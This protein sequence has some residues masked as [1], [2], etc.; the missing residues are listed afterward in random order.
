L[1]YRHNFPVLNLAH[2]M[3]LIAETDHT[4]IWPMVEGMLLVQLSGGGEHRLVGF[5]SAA[6][7]RTMLERG[8]LKRDGALLHVTK[9]GHRAA[10]RDFVGANKMPRRRRPG[11]TV[12]LSVATTFQGP[13]PT[14][15]LCSDSAPSKYLH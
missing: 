14:N 10:R 12:C 5:L 2:V 3:G 15:W 7:I 1:K 13:G 8:W 4:A 6:A 9:D 11:G